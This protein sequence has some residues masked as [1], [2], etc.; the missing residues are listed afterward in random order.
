MTNSDKKQ[1]WQARLQ[2]QKESGLTIAAW[3]ENHQVSIAQFYYWQKKLNST[4]EA[5]AGNVIV[6]IA[7][8]SSPALVVETPNGYRLLI[9]DPS[10]IAL[11]PQL[12]NTLS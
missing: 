1:R 2:Q 11:L 10:A 6:P 12:M 9:N 4:I 8:S 3:C 5:S 7:M